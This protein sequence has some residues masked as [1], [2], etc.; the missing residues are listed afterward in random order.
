MYCREC[1]NK[2]FESDKF[3]SNCG[4]KINKNFLEVNKQINISSDKVVPERNNILPMNWYNFF[5]YF[6]LPL[7]I[8]LNTYT[9]FTY[10]YSSFVYNKIELGIFFIN[11]ALIIL[12]VLSFYMLHKRVKNTMTCIIIL[13]LVECLSIIGNC[14]N[15]FNVLTYIVITFITFVIWFIPN[16]IYFKKR[17]DIF[18]N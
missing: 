11:I 12:L 10:N 16:Y 18:I 17:E 8:V 15:F 3:C 9:L 7:G 1:G 5:T 2:L 4:I 14:I 13:L 6:R